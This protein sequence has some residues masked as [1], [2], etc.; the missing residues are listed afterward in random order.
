MNG[1]M[2]VVDNLDTVPIADRVKYLENKKWSFTELA[3]DLDKMDA[4]RNFARGKEL[5]TVRS[6]NQCH[7]I[8]ADGG[9]LGPDLNELP[10]KL[11]S[12]KFA[13]ADLLREVIDPAANIDKKYQLVAFELISG[14]NVQGIIVHE[15][16]NVI[17]VAK[18]QVEPPVEIKRGDVAER[19]PLP[20]LSFM[21]N[22]LL[23][24]LTREDVLDLL[25]YV[26]AAGDE[27]A[28]A[29]RKD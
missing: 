24:R 11:A 17:R 28:P 9:K 16:G 12:G 19:T 1:I 4:G 22:G 6:C 10:K 3:G 14:Q 20:K 25:A 27:R 5:F 23:D 7:K 13:K 2:N 29:F 15:D 26:A 18:N 8:G 21:P